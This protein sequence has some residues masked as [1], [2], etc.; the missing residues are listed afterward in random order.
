MKF[1]CFA[2][3]LSAAILLTACGGSAELTKHVKPLDIT[4]IDGT[5]GF[6][7]A[8]MH[9]TASLLQKAAEKS[10][11]NLLISPYLAASAWLTAADESIQNPELF[12][13]MA[14]A[15]LNG[16]FVKWRNS[17]TAFQAAQSLWTAPEQRGSFSSDY[18]RFCLGLSGTRVFAA[19]RS[20]EAL[21]QWVTDATGGAFTEI[22]AA[23][24][25]GKA[26]LSAAAYSLSWDKPYSDNEVSNVL[27]YNAD[28][29]Q[30]SLPFLCKDADTAVYLE[31]DTVRGIRRSC[32]ETQYAF[33]ILMPK[34]GSVSD[35][36]QNMTAEQLTDYV[37]G[38]YE[39]TIRTGIPKYTAEDTQEIAALLPDAGCEQIVQ[40]LRT[41]IGQGTET[42]SYS[43]SIGSSEKADVQIMFDHPFAFF[44]LDRYYGLPLFVGTV[45]QLS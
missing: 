39:R 38:G 34:S 18:L 45:E 3:A 9:F 31:D 4:P 13:G 44:V 12:G 23:Q 32:K 35:L 21:N 22:N 17:Q 11:G 36:L 5:Q 42:A 14:R 24:D 30:K 8:Q 6:C 2:A 43:L 26:M 15:E 20:P 19:E 29:S 25:G 10:D 40:C 28:G 33:L 16:S 7:D 41:E 1:R 27:F 37:R